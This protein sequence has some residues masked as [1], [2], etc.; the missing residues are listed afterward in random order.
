MELKHKLFAILAI[1]CILGSACAV[2]AAEDVDAMAADDGDFIDGSHD[3]H[4]GAIIPPDNT[5]DE[6]GHAAGAD[7]YLDG[8]QDGHNGTIIPPDYAHNES[9]MM[10]AT[11]STGNSTH[12]A[13][14]DVVNSTGNATVNATAH[15][16]LPATGNPIVALIAVAAVLGGASMISKRKWK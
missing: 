15:N 16:A 7:P 5:H 12:A 13:G 9:A 4:D 6:A 3:G 1:F 14:S 11:N 8:S 10:N 2:C